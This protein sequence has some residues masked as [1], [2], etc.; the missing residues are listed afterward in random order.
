MVIQTEREEQ[1]T[2]ENEA[3]RIARELWPDA[4]YNGARIVDGL[5]RDGVFETEDCVHL[6]EATVSRSKAKAQE[7]IKK[8]TSLARKF[9]SKVQHKAV[10]CWFITRTEPTAEQREVAR[11]HRGLVNA[12]SFTQ[13]QSK[14][15]DAAS[16]LNLRENYPFGSVR[17]P[18]TGNVSTVIEYVPLD[19]IQT[20]QTTL[21]SITALRDAILAGDRFVILGDYG[22]GKSMTLR[23]LHRELRRAY[24]NQRTSRFPIYLNLRDHFGQTNPAEVLERHGR[25]LGFSHPSHLV[26]AW[27]AGYVILLIDGFDELTT[28]GIQGLWKQLQDSRY[29]AM[30]AVREF[31]R[32]QPSGSGLVLAGRAHFFDSE[33]ERRAALG[34]SSSFAEL[35]LN[36][37]NDEQIHRYLSKC[38]LTGRVPGWMPARPLLVGYLAASG[39][40]KDLVIPEGSL[41]QDTGADP[42]RGWDVILDR[43]CAREAEIEAG[44]DGQT[45]RR[46]LE[47]LATMAR[48]TDTGLGPLSRE[49]VIGAFS[50]VCGYQPDEKGMV[51]LQRLPGLGIERAD[52]GTRSFIDDDL[53]DACRS[54]DVVAFINDPYGIGPNRF[55]SAECGLG[56][57]GVGLSVIKSHEA[58]FSSGKLSAALKR[59][60]EYED[61]TILV[62]DLA[63]VTLDAGYPIEVPLAFSHIYIPSVELYQGIKDCSKLYFHDCYF[64]KMEIDPDVETAH[65]PRFSACYIDEVEGRSSRK[66]LPQGG[67]FDDACVFGKFSQAPETTNAIGAMDLPLGGRVLLTVLKKIYLQSGSGRKENALHRGLDHHA[68][69][70]VSPILRLLQTEEIVSPY[71]RGGLDMTIWI[72]DRAKM[73]RVGKIITSPHTCGDSLLVKA[74]NLS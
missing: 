2:F 45:V 19:L 63:R 65:L 26:R 22:A 47:R 64:S 11:K 48:S 56:S 46:I 60:S 70:L 30:Q 37:F 33:K 40:L 28:L 41:Q 39:L 17:D 15:I 14:L 54:G 69:R 73:T 55:R 16:Y 51:L 31:V 71:K 29:R 43:V 12:L 18:A 44:I 23:E 52:E 4:Q 59:A 35:T 50:D 66:D 72:P 3:R 58:K 68:R 53:A 8:L 7:D 67:A 10:K 57:L 9:Q 42:A 34:L 36:E 21:W 25:S 27:R 32:E 20:G 5:E 6:L 24:F 1:R 74:S 49:R 62:L 38:G 13:F 61:V